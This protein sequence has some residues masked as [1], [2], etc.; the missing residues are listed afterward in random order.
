MSKI[1]INVS[2]FGLPPIYRE[3]ELI[4][5]QNVKIVGND[6]IKYILPDGTEIKL[7]NVLLQIVRLDDIK[8]ING[9][10]M[11]NIQTQ[12]IIQVTPPETK[13]NNE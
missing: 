2:P 8:D 6:M 4:P 5:V 9:N 3:G 12:N 7:K 11:Y 1:S 10:P 13:K